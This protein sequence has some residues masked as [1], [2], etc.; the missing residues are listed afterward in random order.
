[1]DVTAKKY[2][3]A[4]HIDALK[5]AADLR[6]KAEADRVAA[7]DNLRGVVVDAV[8]NGGASYG[9]ITEI[10]GVSDRTSQKWVRESKAD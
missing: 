4:Q 3:P 9:V 8:V 10:T 5:K 7:L 2:P 6:G 1:M